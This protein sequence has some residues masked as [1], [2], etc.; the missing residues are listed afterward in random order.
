[1]CVWLPSTKELWPSLL[2]T[3]ARA[4]VLSGVFPPSFGVL[5]Q[6]GS[7]VQGDPEVR[8]HQGST[9]VPRGFHEVRRGGPNTYKSTACC[10]DIA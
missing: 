1:M 4:L 8:F 3:V 2:L 10:W 9:R 5:A 7:G 6:I